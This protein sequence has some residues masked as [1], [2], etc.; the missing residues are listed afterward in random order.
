MYHGDASADFV[1]AKLFLSQ[2]MLNDM[3]DLFVLES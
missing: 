2:L 3:F 1:T